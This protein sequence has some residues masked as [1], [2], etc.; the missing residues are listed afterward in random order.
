MIGYPF[1]P[2]DSTTL[3][4][5]IGMNLEGHLEKLEEISGVAS[6]EWSLEKAL[7]R[8]LSEW[9]PLELTCKEYRDT[10]T[11]IIGGVDDTS[12]CSTTTSSSRRRCRAARSSSRSPRARRRGSR[13]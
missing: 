5:V 2:T 11:Y 4:S 13:S 6:K 3:T 7:D 8:M 10:G 12:C 1:K 9:Q